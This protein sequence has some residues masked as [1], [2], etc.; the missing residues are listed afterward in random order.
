MRQDASQPAPRGFVGALLGAVIAAAAAVCTF[1]IVMFTEIG[2]IFAAHA[3]RPTLAGRAIWAA[4]ILLL[5]A[6]TVAGLLAISQAAVSLVLLIGAWALLAYVAVLLAADWYGR[7]EPAIEPAPVSGAVRP[8][9]A[10]PS[11]P[12]SNGNGPYSAASTP[13]YF[14]REE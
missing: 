6:W 9:W 13:R 14:D 5:V 8:S 3:A 11:A 2:Q 1:L 4:T 7:H 12:S 10:R